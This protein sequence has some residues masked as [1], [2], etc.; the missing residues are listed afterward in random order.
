MWHM[1]TTCRFPT[2]S[3][4]LRKPWTW[5]GRNNHGVCHT[6]MFG[7]NHFI[8]RFQLLRLFHWGPTGSL[9]AFVCNWLRWRFTRRGRG[10]WTVLFKPFIHDLGWNLLLRKR[11]PTIRVLWSLLLEQFHHH[12]WFNQRGLAPPMLRRLRAK[13][14]SNFAHHCLLITQRPPNRITSIQMQWFAWVRM[15]P[16]L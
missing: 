5:V 10:C 8:H 13:P 6:T 1:S 9:I 3:L 2:L 16:L 15:M 11:E 14:F 7:K 12:R 4:M